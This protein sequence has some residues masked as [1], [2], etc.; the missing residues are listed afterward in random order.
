MQDS[1]ITIMIADKHPLFREGLKSKLEKYADFEI[2]GEN[3]EIDD[4]L[5]ACR[6]YAPNI[7]LTDIFVP[8]SEGIRIIQQFQRVS[9]ATKILI[10]SDNEDPIDVQIVLSEGASGYIL[11]RATSEEFVNAIRVIS[12]NGSYLP[13]TIMASLID[14]AKKT[15]YTG[16]MFGLTSRELDILR[17]LAIGS[18]NKNIAKKLS[19]SVRTVETHRQNIRQKTGAFA[20][21]DLVRIAAR[22]GLTHQAAV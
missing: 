8:G 16:N 15:R 7:L 10:A 3:D 12:R 6:H 22:I 1:P 5:D 11:K 14:A 13:A 4:V 19:I 18:C 21:A 9:H 17:E 2:V 20:T